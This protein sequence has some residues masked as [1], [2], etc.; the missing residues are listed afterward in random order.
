MLI[1]KALFTFLALHSEGSRPAEPTADWIID[2]RWFEAVD[3][4]E[5]QPL[6]ERVLPHTVR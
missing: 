3:D 4:D 6:M 2:W 1:P 5:R